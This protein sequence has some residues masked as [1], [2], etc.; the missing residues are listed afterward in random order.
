MHLCFL[1]FLFYFFYTVNPIVLSPFFT[2]LMCVY[3]RRERLTQTNIALYD[4]F[5]SC[6]LFIMTCSSPHHP[7]ESLT[8]GSSNSMERT[9]VIAGSTVST[10]TILITTAV[11]TT[12]IVMLRRYMARKRRQLREEEEERRRRRYIVYSS[13]HIHIHSHGRPIAS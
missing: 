2:V 10:L 6:E 7:V 13:L 12:L 5:I 11:V 4:S 1:F 8:S 3:G 9:E